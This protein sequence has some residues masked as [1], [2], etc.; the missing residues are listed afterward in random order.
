MV[1]A[2]L[3]PGIASGVDHFRP[4]YASAKPFKH[5]VFDDLFEPA[6]CRELMAGFP[7]FEAGGSLNERGEQGRKAVVTDLAKIGPAYARFDKLM[8]DREFLALI[9]RI[10]GID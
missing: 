2:L 9:G 10:T 5:V 7:S 6:F 8:R 4:Q 3:R 1:T